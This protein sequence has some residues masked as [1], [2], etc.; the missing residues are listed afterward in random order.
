MNEPETVSPFRIAFRVE[1]P[2]IHAYFAA[3]E[4]MEGAQLLG[5]ILKNICDEDRAVWEGF[6]ALMR[7]AMTSVMRAAIG[8]E[9]AEFVEE[10]A[11]ENERAGSA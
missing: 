10:P 9:A 3:P 6:K 8:V 7:Q 2:M 4:T 1:G 5:G 11:P